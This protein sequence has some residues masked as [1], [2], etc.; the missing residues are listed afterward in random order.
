MD[1]SNAGDNRPENK[2]QFKKGDPRINRKG[3]P[4]NFDAL[5]ELAQQIAHEVAQSEGGP[6]VIDGHAVTV[7]EAI[8]R[9]WA[10]SKDARLQQAFIKVAYGEDTQRMELTGQGGGPVRIT[11]VIVQLPTAAE[12]A[13]AAA[14]AAENDE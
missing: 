12:V 8:M 5:R 6:L 14:E 3:R 2:G 4:R 1:A 7:A 11:E 13:E 9:K 10:T